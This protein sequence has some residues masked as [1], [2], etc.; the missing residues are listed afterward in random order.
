MRSLAVITVTISL[1][2][3]CNCAGNLQTVKETEGSFKDLPDAPI[4]GSNQ[5]YAIPVAL[6]TYSQ[7]LR[8]NLEDGEKQQHQAAVFHALLDTKDG[9]ITSWYSKNRD[10]VYGKVR[11]VYSYPSSAGYCRVYQ[12]FIT[13]NGSGRNSINKGCKEVDMPWR[14]LE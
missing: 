9:Q 10:Q 2:L 11:V 12:S 1:F 5:L 7:Y 13:V 14:F 6:W 8:F 3:L 4:L